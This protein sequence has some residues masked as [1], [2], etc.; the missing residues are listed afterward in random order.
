MATIRLAEPSD[1]PQILGIYNDIILNTTAVYEYVPHTLEMREIW[2]QTLRELELPVFVAEDGDRIVGFAS[3]SPFRKWGAY[4][5]SVENSIYIAADRRGT[6]IGTQLLPRL[7]D[8]ARARGMHTIVAGID[9][10]N[11]SSLRLHERFG[12]R[13]VANFRQV[14]FKFGRWL[15]L[16]FL[17]LML[18][19][20][21]SP[22]D[23]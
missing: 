4:K 21:H 14:G 10:T 22:L 19:T 7:I 1:L 11:Q 9:T 16:K 8:A 2:F 5:Y 18:E 20:P 17:Q 23:G 15:D 13:E 3:L 6:G 12:F